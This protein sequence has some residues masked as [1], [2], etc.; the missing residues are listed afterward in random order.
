MSILEL[1]GVT[2]A[3]G[4]L[5]AADG[6]N[7][8]FEQGRITGLIGPNGAG[9]TTIF[10]IMSGF[11]RADEGEV[12][13]RG[14]DITGYT[15]WRIAQ[16][17]IGRAFQDVHLFSRMTAMDNVLVAFRGQ[18]GENPLMSVFGRWKTVAR[19]KTCRERATALLDFVGLGEKAGD[20]AEDLS[21]G[22][23]KLL[24]IAR[25]LA[26]DAD[27][28]LLDE[29]TAGVNPRMIDSLLDVIKR[30][31]ADGKTVVFI[32]HNM[33]V[34]IEIADWVYFLNEGQVDA[35]GTPGEVLGD[36]EVRKAY[37]GV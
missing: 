17:G 3:F 15:P 16:L 36:A 21:Y 8:G 27:I 6:I 34:V 9:K 24:S 19:D 20:L 29:P 4:G 1:R 22:Q 5:R 18:T 12:C 32:E 10:N 11:L 14:R 23:Q 28:L 25:L 33:N 13:C 37:I 30:M 35:F 26:A 31:A 2:K 7:M